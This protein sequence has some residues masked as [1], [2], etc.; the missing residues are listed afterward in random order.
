M[1]NAIRL[2]YISATL[3]IFVLLLFILSTL[4]SELKRPILFIATAYM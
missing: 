4:K 2:H 3:Q 1:F